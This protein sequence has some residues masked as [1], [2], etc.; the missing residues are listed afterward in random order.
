MENIIS[1]FTVI[2]RT[3]TPPST[4]LKAYLRWDNWDDFGFKTTHSLLISDENGELHEIGGVKIGQFNMGDD[5]RRP[6]VPD[7]F[8]CLDES[9]FSLGQD[10]SYYDKLNKLGDNIKSHVLT[11]LRDIVFDKLLYEKAIEESVTRTSLFRF[12]SETT[13]LVQYRRIVQGGARLTPYKFKYQLP[14]QRNAENACELSFDVEHDTNPPSNIHVL[15]GRNG[16]GKTRILKFMA[17]ALIH[18]DSK[19]DEYGKFYSGEILPDDQLFANL[20]SVT[21]S[22]FDPFDPIEERHIKTAD[23]NYSYVGLKRM[24]PTSDGQMIAVTKTDEELTSEFV[25]C[26]GLCNSDQRAKRWKNALSVLESDLIFKEAN[27]ESL[28]DIR[29][30]KDFKNRA[31]KIFKNLSSGHKIVLLTIT[32]LIE[33]VAERTLVLLDEPEAH[34]HPPLLSAFIRALSDLLIDRNGVSVIA[35]HSPVVLQEVPKSCVYKIS[36]VGRKTKAERP[37]SETFGENVGVLTREVFGLE[38]VSSGFHK[39]IQD[40]VQGGRRYDYVV[41]HFNGELGAEAKAIIQ[42]LIAARDAQP[43]V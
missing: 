43:E 19:K 33:T 24:E 7:L 17:R 28:Q 25:K 6:D 21:F 1:S 5:K 15:I 34:L 16:V 10:D 36:R 35:T 12:V 31:I 11:S 2:S 37:E 18:M 41:N 3:K 14:Q 4:P 32:R 38:V 9:F 40:A 30:T 26:L 39:L 13:V 27:V 22:A 20:V 42:A 8:N 23:I 29:E